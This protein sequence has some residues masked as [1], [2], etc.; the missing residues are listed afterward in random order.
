MN[1]KINKNK[2]A[3]II[4]T[5]IISLFANNMVCSADYTDGDYTTI[6]SLKNAGKSAIGKTI[7]LTP[8]GVTNYKRLCLMNNTNSTDNKAT[9]PTEAYCIQ[10]NHTFTGLNKFKVYSYLEI[11]GKNR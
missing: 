11:D 10:Y 7:Y 8:S 3:L 1:I 5:F 6:Q 2:V 4:L 9:I